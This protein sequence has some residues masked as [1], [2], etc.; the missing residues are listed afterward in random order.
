MRFIR[1]FGITIALTIVV[2]L[3]GAFILK[4]LID[5]E[6]KSAIALQDSTVGVELTAFVDSTYQPKQLEPGGEPQHP[7]MANTDSSTMHSGSWE[8]DVHPAFAVYDKHPKI[9]TRRAGG[10]LA[11]QCATF[12]FTSNGYPVIMCGGLTGFRLQLIHPEN[13]DLLAYFDLPMRPSAFQAM[14]EKNPDIT[15]TDSSGG[16]YFYLDNEDRVVVADSKQVLRRIKPV[17]HGDNN[18]E[19]EVTDRWDLGDFVP[20]DC[21][22]YNN[23]SPE[24]ECDNITT[25]MPD[26]NGLIWWVTRNGRVGSLNPETGKVQHTGLD[27]EEIQ[28]SFALD[29]TGAYIISDY[30]LYKMHLVAGKP[31]I[32]WRIPYDRGSGRNVGSIN[33]GSGTSPTLL[34]TDYITFT[35]NA[36]DYMHILVARRGALAEGQ[37]RLICSVPVFA[38]GRSATDNSMIGYKRSI[39]LENNHGYTN[40]LMQTDYDAVTG[41]V[42]RI[43]IREDETGCD[44]VWRNEL[45]VP[46]V[47]PKLSLGNGI[48]YFYSFELLEN[49]DR[50]WSLVGLDFNTGKEVL[51]I[52]TG[53][54]EAFNNNWS[55]IAIAPNGDTYVG[56][57][58][59]FIQLKSK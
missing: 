54:G 42:V 40:S 10:A 51:R 23:L 57:R 49:K 43:D 56:T 6:E 17:Q 31:E 36:D 1:I 39:I 2:L 5:R 41:G 12:A 55:S 22:H 59:G 18:W 28:N 11:R 25:V 34:G 53:T 45:K 7:Y 8:S 21:V 24:G 32:L 48:A 38:K 26:Y 30:A 14:I 52:P 4:W 29:E 58:K 20:H 33:Q 15:F 3:V 37:K 35:D 9:L 27:G 16:A 13:L 19:F 46:S 47:V 50:L 44:I